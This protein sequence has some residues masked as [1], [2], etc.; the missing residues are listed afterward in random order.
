MEFTRTKGSVKTDT[1]LFKKADI[2]IFLFVILL[3]TFLLLSSIGGDDGV[4]LCVTVDGKSQTYSLSDD[5][6]KEF[7]GN[8]ITLTLTVKNGEAYVSHSECKDKIC[9]RSG[10]ISKA[11]QIIVCAPANI[12]IKI[13]GSGG[14]FDALTR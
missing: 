11:G 8:G 3:A 4:Q 5:F 2:L 14:E 9:Q 12:S 13:I 1:K 6:I 7:S 10:K